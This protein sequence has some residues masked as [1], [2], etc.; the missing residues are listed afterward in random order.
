MS[1]AIGNARSRLLPMD[2]ASRPSAP[3]NIE[4]ADAAVPPQTPAVIRREDYRPP[5][6]LVP[7]V[8][9]DFALGLA[10]TRVVSKLQVRKRGET[11]TLR[12]NGDGITPQA[13]H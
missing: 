1:L 2:I 8:S 4:T 11:A 10:G 12:L 3:E 5:A 6:W 13:V 9:L 7:E